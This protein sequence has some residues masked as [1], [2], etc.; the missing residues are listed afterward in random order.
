LKIR[1]LAAAATFSAPE[2]LPEVIGAVQKP[3]RMSEP[4]KKILIVTDDIDLLHRLFRMV[5]D[6]F[7][8]VTAVDSSVARRRAIVYEPDILVIS[9]YLIPDASTPWAGAAFIEWFRQNLPSAK[10]LLMLPGRDT[11][12]ESEIN[13]L[14][15]EMVSIPFE[16]NVF[17]SV[18]RNSLQGR[19]RR[20]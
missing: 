11:A 9:P 20:Y 10:V 12:S 5:S 14:A 2:S 15:D 4:K 7:E 8:V 1:D 19:E 13:H 17:T 3:V 16:D 6:E 18:L